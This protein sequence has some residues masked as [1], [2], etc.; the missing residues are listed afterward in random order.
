M[1]HKTSFGA[2]FL[3]IFL[4]IVFLFPFIYMFGGALKTNEEALTNPASV[5]PGRFHWENFKAV[6]TESKLNIPIQT[7]NSLITTFAVTLGQILVAAL[8]GYAFARIK[9]IWRD[10]L[11]MIFLATLIVPFELL[12]VPLYLML[13]KW[14]WINT[15][16]ALIITSLGNPFAIFMFRQFFITVPKELEEAMVMDGAG[17][18]RTFWSLM[19]P[20]SG[21]PTI[22]IFILTWLAEWSGLLKQML[23]TTSEKMW[24][25]QVGLNFLNRGAQ[26]T[27]PTIAYLMAGI[28][29]ATI[30]P[31]IMFLI[32]QRRFVESIAATGL[33]G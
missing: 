32:M 31:V 12:F 6:F 15:Y 11:F 22:S 23:F 14:G 25:L 5:F 20:L 17:Y 4:A 28:V 27:T 18:F 21:P 19:L 8:A 33:K 26:V 30:P 13:A 16:W 10:P 9:F 3:L 24:T 7:K 29:L 1:K 2:M